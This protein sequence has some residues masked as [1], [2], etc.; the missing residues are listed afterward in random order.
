LATVR[1]RTKSSTIGVQ[2]LVVNVLILIVAMYCR[3]K[4]RVFGLAKV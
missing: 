4:R 3:D 1:G 2:A